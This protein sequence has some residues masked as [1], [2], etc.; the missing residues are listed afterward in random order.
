[1][2]P[3][4]DDTLTVARRDGSVSG[5]TIFCD[6][7]SAA[8]DAG[9][10]AMAR[11]SSGR[12][13]SDLM[14]GSSVCSLKTLSAILAADQDVAIDRAEGELGPAGRDARPEL[15]VAAIAEAWLPVPAARRGQLRRESALDAAV[16]RREVAGSRRVAGEAHHDRS[17]DGARPAGAAHL[18]ERHRSVDV[19]DV[20]MPAHPGD[21]HLAVLDRAGDELDVG[22]QVHLEVK[23]RLVAELPP[24][25]EA[26]AAVP[27]PEG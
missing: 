9:E 10:A 20:E 15:A 3:F 25:V 14:T 16:H 19:A 11:I 23:P 8:R 4:S 6:G 26:G 21:A 22:W 1:M 13:I 12:A 18:L 7:S 17:V 5:T 27:R 2:P 24:A